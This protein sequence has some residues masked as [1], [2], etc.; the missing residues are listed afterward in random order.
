MP[1]DDLPRAED[2]ARS[3]LAGNPTHEALFT[4][5]VRGRG[6]YASYKDDPLI[7]FQIQPKYRDEAGAR[8]CY[9]AASS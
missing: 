2:V 3:C 6:E 9:A 4:L 5:L 8:G 7:L 1:A